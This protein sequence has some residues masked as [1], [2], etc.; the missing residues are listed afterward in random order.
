[1]EINKQE[2][3][4]TQPGYPHETEQDAFYLDVANKLLHSLKGTEVEKVC[5][6]HH[7]KQLALTMTGYF[8]DVVA[9][10]GIWRSFCTLCNELYGKNIPLFED[11]IDDNYIENE[12]NYTDVRFMTWYFL[13]SISSEKGT[14][15]P[16]NPAVTEAAKAMYS[17]LDSFYDDAP[18]HS[19]YTS[20]REIDFDEPDAEMI[21]DIYDTTYWLFWNSY[22]MR[23][24]ATPTI[25]E[26]L[27][28]GKKIIAKADSADSAAEL[29]DQLNQRTL[30]EN[31]TG[32]LS[33][34]A[35][36]WMHQIVDNVS[37][38]KKSKKMPSEP[39]RFY[40]SFTNATGGKTIHFCPSYESLEQFLTNDMQWGAEPNGHFPQLKDYSGFVLYASQEKGLLIAPEVAQY[41]K[42]PDN[43]SYDADKARNEAHELI[44]VQGRCPIDLVKY[45][46]ANNLVPDATL[47]WDNSGKALLDNWDF[48][49]RL[50]LQSYYRAK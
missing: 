45:L 15:A 25:R 11:G 39:H 27:E 26:S 20:L 28:E 41:I 17:V 18:V 31:P 23:H 12:L 22:F 35:H 40:T 14:L 37:P 9:D 42:H 48:L 21:H 19:D 43:P 49:A 47:P 30:E 36:E 13:E 8:Q 46:F 10:A 34:Y 7:C 32:P 38:F 4:I 24:A 2:F 33:L 6:Q 50:Y 29:I 1:M 16:D 44:T 3:L 5:G